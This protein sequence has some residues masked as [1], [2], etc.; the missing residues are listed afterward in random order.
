MS[1]IPSVSLAILLAVALIIAADRLM[2]AANHGGRPARLL[3][4][5][6]VPVLVVLPGLGLI[7][8]GVDVLTGESLAAMSIGPLVGVV[9]V[10][11]LLLGGRQWSRDQWHADD[12]L[13]LA[14]PAVGVLLM[15]LAVAGQVPAF[16]SLVAFALGA[17]LVWM[18]TTPRAGEGHGGEGGGWVLLGLLLGGAM[19][20][21]NAASPGGWPMMAVAIA[22]GG[23]V[24]ARACVRL[25]RRRAILAVGWAA[26]MGPILGLGVLGQD[27]LRESVLSTFNSEVAFVGYR[28]FGGLAKLLLPGV[29]L[30]AMCGFVAGWP[31]WSASRGRWVAILMAGGGVFTI[32][33]VLARLN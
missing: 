1:L 3:G 22:A 32:A 2:L 4:V 21:T 9:V 10:P 7:Q 13:P 28:G 26:M 15:A 27:D 8:R 11:L 5:L 29:L 6:W 33:A 30:L 19:A 23:A 17:V 18:E 24:M 14:W 31:R 12:H 25:G 20:A 16:L